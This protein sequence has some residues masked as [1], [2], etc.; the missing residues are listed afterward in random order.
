MQIVGVAS[1]LQ[2]HYYQQE[3]IAAALKQHWK[4]KCRTPEELDQLLRTVRVAGRHWSFRCKHTTHLRLGAKLTM[5]GSN[6]PKN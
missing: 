3:E 6:T 4:E 5:H 2:D 1:T